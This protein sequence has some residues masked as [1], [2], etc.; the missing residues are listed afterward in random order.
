MGTLI[1][2]LI[3]LSTYLGNDLRDECFFVDKPRVIALFC[4]V[5]WVE[6]NYRFSNRTRIETFFRI[7]PKELNHFLRLR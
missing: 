7:V 5:I 1:C 2:N 3:L 4:I 6:I